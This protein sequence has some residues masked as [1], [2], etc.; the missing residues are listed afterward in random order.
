MRIPP[1]INLGRTALIVYLTAPISIAMA[2]QVASRVT[3]I[4][5]TSV[6]LQNLHYFP[7][8][9]SIIRQR[10]HPY[11]N[12]SRILL[13]P[14]R[15]KDDEILISS[16]QTTYAKQGRNIASRPFTWDE[17]VDIVLH[18][19]DLSLFSRSLEEQVR[20]TRY[21][22]AL[23]TRWKSVNDHILHSKFKFE[24]RLVLS[25]MQEQ[26][27]T[28]GQAGDGDGVGNGDLHRSLGRNDNELSAYYENCDREGENKTPPTGYIWEVYPTLAEVKSPLK[29][30]LPNDFPYYIEDGIEHWCL[31]KLKGRVTNDDIQMA[32]D[33]LKQMMVE[34]NSSAQF[35]T[36]MS[37]LENVD[38]FVDMLHWINPPHLKSIPDI[39]HAHILCLRR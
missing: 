6:Y 16:I 8:S 37:S 13:Q 10:K 26:I 14:Q 2:F 30:L 28:N 17:L 39:D 27:I 34:A 38:A 9:S 11:H 5:N 3:T 32:K 35:T 24:K 22:A 12:R 18:K 21:V 31:W 33:D 15:S 20:Y 4:R 36:N 23:K 7:L 19:K 29:V 1:K 25:S